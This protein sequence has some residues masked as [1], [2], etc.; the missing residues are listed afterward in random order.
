MVG[1]NWRRHFMSQGINLYARL[2][3][4]LTSRDNSGS[5][6]CYQV[7]Q[8]AELDLDLFRARGYAFQEEILYRLNRLGSRFAET[9]IVFEDR[10]FGESKISWKESVAALWILF[11]LAID[12]LL[13]VE[14][15][16]AKRLAE[17]AAE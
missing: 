5:F 13:R 9:P 7:K 14:V 10:R 11:R 16:R 1:W 2:M 3:L 8:L 12:R 17:T 4:G 6:R 15:R